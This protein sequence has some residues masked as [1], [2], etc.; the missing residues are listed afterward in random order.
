MS[1]AALSD[2]TLVE[3]EILADQKSIALA[4]DV[5]PPD[6]TFPADSL[7]LGQVLSNL[8][9]NGIKYTPEGGQVNV[10]AHH[11]DNGHVILRVSDTGLGI[12]PDV[13]PRLFEKFYRI[14]DEAYYSQEGTGLGLSIVQGIV[15]Q[16]G[17]SIAVESEVG[18]GS[19]FSVTLPA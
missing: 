8:V 9:S 7:R 15:E 5:D 1:A 17:G 13:V 19:T 14:P 2:E 11:R 18:K 10:T 4:Y 6:L 12:P 3:F 16:H